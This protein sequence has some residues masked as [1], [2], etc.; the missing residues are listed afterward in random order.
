MITP[1][2]LRDWKE[3]FRQVR[4]LL[5]N[6]GSNT[7]G[8]TPAE[9][10]IDRLIQY[11]EELKWIAADWQFKYQAAERREKELGAQLA[12]AQNTTDAYREITLLKHREKVALRALETALIEGIGTLDIAGEIQLN[13]LVRKA[14]EKAE[15]EIL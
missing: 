11:V 6:E 2:E 13:Q 7:K 15:K 9:L 3:D 8:L 12:P 1:E 10:F 5:A 4:Q 14:L